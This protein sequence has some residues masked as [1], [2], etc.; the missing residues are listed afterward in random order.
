MAVDGVDIVHE[1]IP[2]HER[3]EGC[4]EKTGLICD[5]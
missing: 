3:Y 2:S 4:G 1:G 5:R